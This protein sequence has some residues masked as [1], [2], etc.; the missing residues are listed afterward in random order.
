MII[1][2]KSIDLYLY[3]FLVEIINCI[4][5]KSQYILFAKLSI[6]YV[7]NFIKLYLYKNRI[8]FIMK[9]ALDNF[10]CWLLLRSVETYYGDSLKEAVLSDR[11]SSRIG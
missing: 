6:L 3:K 5:F 8:I 10:L 1:K 2:K 4:I 7:C 11:P 9:V